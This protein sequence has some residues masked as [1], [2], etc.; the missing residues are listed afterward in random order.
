MKS[1]GIV[2]TVNGVGKVLIPKIIGKTFE[3]EKN[4]MVEITSIDDKIYLK[5]LE[6]GCVF[7]GDDSQVKI[8]RD[9]EIC[10]ACQNEIKRISKS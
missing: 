10:S 3:I 4:G 5:K 2:Q 7:C 1:T 9:K 6:C 8:Y